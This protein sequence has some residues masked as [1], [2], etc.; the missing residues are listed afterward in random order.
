MRSQNFSKACALKTCISRRKIYAPGSQ[1]SLKASVSLQPR[2]RVFC[3]H[4]ARCGE[5]KTLGTRLVACLYRP[6]ISLLGLDRERLHHHNELSDEVPKP[7]ESHSFENTHHFA[8]H[9][10]NTSNNN[11]NTNNDVNDDTSTESRSREGSTSDGKDSKSR[12]RRTAFTS[13]QLKCLE[14]TFQANK[15][16]TTMER[17]RL[18]RALNLSKKQVSLTV[19][20]GLI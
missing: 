11:N 9:N 8:Q 4:G 17:D 16:L 15:Y 10:G 2:P 20:Y 14:E 6:N 3:V 19:A 12:R 18:A 13:V 1:L 5:T 7:P